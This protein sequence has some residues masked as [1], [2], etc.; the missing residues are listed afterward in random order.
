MRTSAL[1]TLLILLTVVASA[2]AAGQS[3]D[4]LKQAMIKESVE[5]HVGPCPCPYSKMPDGS[6]C[7]SRS[8]YERREGKKPLCFAHDITKGMLYLYRKARPQ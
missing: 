4:V 7:G 2:P 8:A 5:S 3:D 1:P 6:T